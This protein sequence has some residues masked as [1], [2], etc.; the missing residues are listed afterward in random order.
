[1][2]IKAAW[3]WPKHRHID[4]WNRMGDPDITAHNYSHLILDKDVK[5]YIY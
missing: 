5:M 4:L 1:M 2:V 3:Y